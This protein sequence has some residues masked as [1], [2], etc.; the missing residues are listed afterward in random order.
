M[1]L[2]NLQLLSFVIGCLAYAGLTVFCIVTWVRGITGRAAFLAAVAT[3]LFVATLGVTGESRWS[4]SVEHFALFSWIVLLVR[5]IGLNPANFR[6]AELRTVSVLIAFAALLMVTGATYAWFLPP[7]A[8]STQNEVIT[9]LFISELLLCVSGLVA[10]EQLVRNTRSDYRWR[11]RYLNIGLGMMF[12]YGLFHSASTLFFGIHIPLLSIVQPT[13]LAIAVPFIAVAS[14]RNRE[15]QLKFNLSR[16]FV[17]RTGVLIVTGGVLL[18]MGL[19]GYYLQLFGGD[20]ASAAA[21]FSATI[22]VVAIFVVAGSTRFQS[23]ARRFIAQNLYDSKHDYR[24]EWASV[25]RQLTEPNPDYNLGQQS[26]RAFLRVLDAS[27][28]CLWR[29]TDAQNFVPIAS[30]HVSWEQSLS[31]QT[32]AKLVEL[33][34]ENDRIIDVEDPGAT[35]GQFIDD[36]LAGMQGIRFVIPL[37]V[38]QRLF[39][40]IAINQ[41]RLDTKLS[42]EDYDILKLISNQA[43]GFLALQHADSVLSESQRLNTLN[44]VTAFVVHDVKTISA[45]LSLMVENAERHKSNPAFIEDM[46]KTVGNAVERMQG[47]LGHLKSEAGEAR[48]ELDLDQLIRASLERFDTQVPRPIMCGKVE[49]LRVCANPEKLSSVI[50]HTVQNAIDATGE[51]G[52]V[53]VT[54]SRRQQW[55]EVLI[56]DDGEGMDREFV[57]NQLFQPFE[58]TKGLTGMGIGAYQTREYIRSIGGDVEVA[59]QPGIGTQFTLR[60]PLRS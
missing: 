12:S 60:L 50:G 11:L 59:S 44:R 33:F 19:A 1:T 48:E 52:S 20:I 25:S 37:F 2:E 34:Q 55:A 21:I 47:L 40:L 22:V 15:N 56:E 31:P 32:S 28:G 5:A 8:F 7:I 58:S 14:L 17:F 54:A 3:L 4:S 36:E 45:Q 24:A 9:P 16:E 57:E 53:R 10:V 46:L 27:G 6:S 39:G 29:L 38:D 49:S 42:W 13:I 43:A 51:S 41:P 35:S 18:L 26:I 23:R 30:M